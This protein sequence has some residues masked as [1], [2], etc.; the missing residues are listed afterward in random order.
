RGAMG[1]TGC[2]SSFSRLIEI[3]TRG[4]TNV[5]TYIDDILAFSKNHEE[6]LGHLAA[7]LDRMRKHSL[8]INLDKCRFGTT[9]TSYL[10]H[11]LT[12]DGVPSF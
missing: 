10:G 11:T 12:S 2:P 1:L 9:E 8:K 6:H 7:V 5:I 4:L 3:A